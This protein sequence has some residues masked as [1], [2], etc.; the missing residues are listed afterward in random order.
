VSTDV[1][2]RFVRRRRWFHLQALAL[3]AAAVLLPL[4][5]HLGD[6]RV[7]A[8]GGGALVL[9]AVAAIGCG[10]TLVSLGRAWHD[11]ENDDLWIDGRPLKGPE[12]ITVALLLLAGGAL[13]IL[14]AIG[15]LDLLAH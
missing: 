5:I 11:V 12:A 15:R 6:Q 13:A 3:G 10:R 7:A 1:V 8:A 14:G 2:E 4:A 9:A